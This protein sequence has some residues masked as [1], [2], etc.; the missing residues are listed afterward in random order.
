MDEGAPLG[1]YYV[2][3]WSKT[4]HA[5]LLR[6]NVGVVQVIFNDRTE[7]IYST[8]ARTLV[9][10][11][12]DGRRSIHAEDE[13]QDC[14][15]LEIVKRLKYTKESVERLYGARRGQ[16]Q[17][18]KPQEPPLQKNYYRSTNNLKAALAE[19]RPATSTLVA[20]TGVEGLTRRG[21]VERGLV[22]TR[23]TTNI[24]R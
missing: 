15:N 13:A 19:F 12:K 23:S 4:Q 3:K 11:G 21:S 20:S 8:E 24:R 16:E 18:N 1:K 5:L 7:I 22:I 10:V 17:E 14:S 6:F 9:Y 2:R